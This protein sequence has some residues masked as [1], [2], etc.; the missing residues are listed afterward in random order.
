[1]TTEAPKQ[2]EAEKTMFEWTAL[3]R[4]FQRRSREFYV[5]LLSAV[6]LV[7][8]ILFVIEGLMPVVLLGALVFL[9]YVLSTVEPERVEYKITSFGVRFA[10]RLT[11]WEKLGK[12]WFVNRLGADL[13]V[14][15]LFAIP[16]RL[17]MVINKSDIPQI[18]KE[19][20]KHLVH[21]EVPPNSFDKAANWAS[22]KLQPR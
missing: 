6:G 13:L 7:G 19:L 10:G 16:G 3:S 15:E 14:F 2:P 17:E 22:K 1:M 21:E 9:F 5:R 11:E 20:K 4:P 12:F 8:A 18:E